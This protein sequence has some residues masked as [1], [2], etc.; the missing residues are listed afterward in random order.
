MKN[1]HD[2]VLNGSKDFMK[3]MRAHKMGLKQPQNETRLSLKSI[4]KCK[5]DKTKV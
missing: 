4:S 2:L 1:M 5:R 3:Q